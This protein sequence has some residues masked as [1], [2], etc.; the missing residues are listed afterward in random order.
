[1]RGCAKADGFFCPKYYI[2]LACRC[3]GVGFSET[4]IRN[5]LKMN[6]LF[7]IR[8]GE[9]HLGWRP[10]DRRFSAQARWLFTIE[11]PPFLSTPS[12]SEPNGVGFPGVQ[13][14][15]APCDDVM[16]PWGARAVAPRCFFWGGSHQ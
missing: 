11:W 8:K 15:N 2:W 14:R 4:A 9:I 13:E 10:R 7:L 12:I 3:I 1:M 16:R 6:C 5:A